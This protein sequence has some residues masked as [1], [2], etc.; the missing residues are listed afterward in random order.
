MKRAVLPLA[1]L[2]LAGA[3]CEH[4][5]PIGP[6]K[7]A[8]A[9]RL[10]P[11]TWRPMGGFMVI[12]GELAAPE[13]LVLEGPHMHLETDADAGPVRW[14]LERPA[15]GER[16]VLKTGSGKVLGDWT[17]GE[18]PKVRRQGA[19]IRTAPSAPT[20]PV[21]LAQ[22]FAP[23]EPAFPAL[24]VAPPDLSLPARRPGLVLGAAATTAKVAAPSPAAVLDTRPP[25]PLRPAATPLPPATPAGLARR[26]ATPG[27]F[28]AVPFPGAGE[29]LNLMHG[30]RAGRRL[31]LTFD[32]GSGAESATEIL[33]TLR[34]RHVR[35]TFF[36]TAAFIQ[37]FPDLVRR[38]ASEG[39]ELGN[40]TTTHPHLAPGMVRDPKWTKARV[41]AELLDADACLVRLLG[42][43]MDPY[44]RAPYGEQTVE[45]RRWAEELGYRHVGWSDGGDSLDWATPAERK[46]YRSGT[47][48]LDKLHGRLQK[49]DGGGLIV[50]MHLGSGRDEVDRPSKGL[51]AFMDRALREGWRFASVGD[52][53][54]DMGKPVWDPA[55]RMAW[56]E[57][58][59][60]PGAR[61]GGQPR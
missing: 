53:L 14:E 18:A 24:A 34:A 48:I 9:T 30:P 42:R 33:D 16:A 54:R 28:P 43:P 37:N 61:G 13:H 19:W 2:V 58:A 36:L 3:G 59:L 60:A 32:G 38:M 40:H 6:A 31:V 41:H 47:R 20:A 52:Y 45:I 8:A 23:A 46:L 15:P 12:E 39:H 26:T 44:W 11:W 7:A 49:P 10:A 35:T 55:A 50:L 56:L 57:P 29:A 17:F 22:P 4:D 27:T 25:A 51:G 21:P 1:L 5:T